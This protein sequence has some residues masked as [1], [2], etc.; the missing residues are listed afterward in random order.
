[1]GITDQCRYCEVC[2]D[3]VFC[4]AEDRCLH[5]KDG[6]HVDPWGHGKNMITEDSEWGHPY[7]S[8]GVGRI[9]KVSAREEKARTEIVKDIVRAKRALGLRRNEDL[10]K[11]FFKDIWPGILAHLRETGFKLP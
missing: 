5:S 4:F 9:T 1:M 11:S 10:R 2:G 3:C 6:V 8:V 7:V